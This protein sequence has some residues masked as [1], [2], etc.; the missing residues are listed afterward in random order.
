MNEYW[1]QYNHETGTLNLGQTYKV[2]F[3]LYKT[4]SDGGVL[5][6]R[7]AKL[8]F[9][10]SYFYTFKYKTKSGNYLRVTIDKYDYK[11]NP[12]MIQEV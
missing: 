3:V 6:E 7:K 9:E 10:N 4:A 2:K 5:L 1:N 12:S 11:R 8:I